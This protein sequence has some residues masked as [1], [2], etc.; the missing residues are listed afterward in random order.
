MIGSPV[1]ISA[2]RLLSETRRNLANASITEVGLDEHWMMPAATY[3]ARG[4]FNEDAWRVADETIIA[5]RK[6]GAAIRCHWGPAKDRVCEADL[7]MIC[8]TP[9]GA[10][11]HW[12]ADS[13]ITFGHL[14]IPDVLARRVADDLGIW[15]SSIPDWRDDLI[16]LDDGALFDAL[17]AYAERPQGSTRPTR[18]EMEARAILI[19]DHLLR[20]YHRTRPSIVTRGGLTPYQL[21]R[22]R[23]H[24]EG[25]L[26]EDISLAELADVVGLSASHFCRAFKRSAGVPP[27]GW[28]ALKRM[29]A[30]QD[31]MLAHPGMGLT[32]IALSVGYQSQAAFGTAFK[33]ATGLSP[34]QWRRARS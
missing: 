16:F 24:M 14:S 18:L 34:N 17:V 15:S 23:E 11:H 7:P 13:H 8:M 28:L 3:E 27:H 4:G 12:T 10:P 21:R 22:V 31:L 1:R 26:C 19:V 29:Q 25:H 9:I 20:T 5:W 2:P 33:R 32:E 30:A 6:S